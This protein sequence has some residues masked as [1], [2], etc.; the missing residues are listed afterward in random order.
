MNPTFNVLVLCTGNSARSILGE[1]LFNHLGQGRV[2]ACSAG[3]KPAGQVNPVALETLE[4]HGVP[5]AGARS[6]SWDEFNA[7]AVPP[8]PTFDFIFTVCGNAAAE[9]C[10]VWPGHPA[11]AHWG[12]D[13]P[14][15]VEPLEA[16]RAAFELAYQLLKQR[17]EAF[18]A[19]PLESMSRD[20]ALAAARRIHA[21]E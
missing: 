9:A 2:K 7:G 17:V 4:K 13:D 11:T 20:E 21:G 19:L 8:A 5:C 16:R 12:I 18:L 15:H 6:K 10:P 3:S 1:M 14:A